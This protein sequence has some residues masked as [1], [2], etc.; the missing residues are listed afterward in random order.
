MKDHVLVAFSDVLKAFRR[1]KRM[2]Q[3][4]LAQG[5]G[6]H[7]NTISGWERGN[8]LPQSKA[9]VVELA[10]C[11]GL[12]EY[13]KQQLLEASFWAVSSYW[14]VPYPRNPLFTGRDTLLQRMYIHLHEQQTLA[15][16]S[17]YALS[18]LG[19]IGKT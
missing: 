12:D 5:L 18:G 6:I 3:Q 17:S 13:E 16:C 15:L 19:G 2:S 8:T 9:M 14:S 11:L 7:S 10:S 1:Q 4:H